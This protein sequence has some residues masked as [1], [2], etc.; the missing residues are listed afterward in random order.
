MTK[1]DQG[2]EY[3]DTLREEARKEGKVVRYVGVIDVKTGK[4]ECKLGK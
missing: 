2:D 1:L 3:F 4:V